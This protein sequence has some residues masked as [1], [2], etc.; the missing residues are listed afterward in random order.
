VNVS[1]YRGKVHE[2]LPCDEG[3]ECLWESA[4]YKKPVYCT[5]KP[6]ASKILPGESCST[7]SDC[8]S[9]SCVSGICLGLKLN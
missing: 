8:L 3:S 6:S 4:V 1:E 9:N 7:N 2:L 5:A